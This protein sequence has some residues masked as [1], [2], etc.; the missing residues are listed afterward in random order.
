M[1]TAAKILCLTISILFAISLSNSY[2]N[3]SLL[4][5]KR[6]QIVKPASPPPG[7]KYQCAM[8]NGVKFTM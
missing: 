3:S 7:F 5:Q 1:K 4:V 8:V 2:A 6:A